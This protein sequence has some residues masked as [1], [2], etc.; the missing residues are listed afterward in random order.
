MKGINAVYMNDNEA[1][2]VGTLLRVSGAHL[3]N[4][5]VGDTVREGQPFTSVTEREHA[6]GIP[7]T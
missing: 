6:C 4:R 3:K 5:A 7:D 2:I 1:L